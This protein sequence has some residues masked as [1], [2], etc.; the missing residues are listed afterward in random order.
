[1]HYRAYSS[2]DEAE[3]ETNKMEDKAR[4]LSQTEHV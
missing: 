3:E 4:E 1:M 2:L